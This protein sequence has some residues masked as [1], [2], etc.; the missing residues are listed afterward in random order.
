MT[1][2]HTQEGATQWLQ[3]LG[4]LG[5][6]IG[7]FVS[8]GFWFVDLRYQQAVDIVGR[9]IVNEEKMAPFAVSW[10]H[11]KNART[12]VLFT[13]STI[14][15]G[16]D[17]H[18]F[19]SSMF[20]QLPPNHDEVP[21]KNLC[22]K[23]D[24]SPF[25]QEVRASWETSRRELR[26]GTWW[27]V[28]LAWLKAGMLILVNK[29]RRTDKK[30]KPIECAR[31]FLRRKVSQDLRLRP[32][33]SP[34]DLNRHLLYPEFQ[35]ECKRRD[36]ERGGET[37]DPILEY[38]VRMPGL[39]SPWDVSVD[40]H[41]L[42]GYENSWKQHLQRIWISDGKPCIE[43]SRTELAALA[44]IMGIRI[45]L[46][47]KDSD[48]P[49]A[50]RKDPKSDVL[51]RPEVESPGGDGKLDSQSQLFGQGYPRS[52]G[53]DGI[54]G[55]GLYGKPLYGDS[56][57]LRLVVGR[58]EHT[59]DGPSRGSGYSTLFAKCMACGCV[60]FETTDRWNRVI[61][62]TK[63]TLKAIKAGMNIRDGFY[64]EGKDKDESARPQKYLNRLPS[65]RRISYY[66]LPG[67]LNEGKIP[68]VC[69]VDGAPIL[70]WPRVVAGI[71]FG[72]LVPMATLNLVRAIR[73]TAE[74][75]NN[76]VEIA[77]EQL[78]NIMID[79]QHLAQFHQLFGQDIEDAAKAK[80][81][82]EMEKMGNPTDASMARAASA[83]SH[84]STILEYAIA[85][86]AEPDAI[87]NGGINVAPPVAH[88]TA[89]QRRH[90]ARAD[91]FQACCKELSDSFLIARR[92]EEPAN[93]HLHRKDET[94]TATV[95]KPISTHKARFDVVTCGRIAR[96][97][98]LVWSYYVTIVVWNDEENVEALK[99]V[100]NNKDR[101]YHPVDLNELPRSC[102]LS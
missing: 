94:H 85:R 50:A 70:A 52:L 37:Q 74:G 76:T 66:G 93:H 51:D 49:S 53:G 8:F 90:R 15:K 2:A 30:W 12:P 42:L 81:G 38:A 67:A 63:G 16:G 77:L 23:L 86:C 28:G 68:H 65:A 56:W 39:K 47:Y 22:H 72:G 14:I 17:E 32:M 83:I 4:A 6:F 31:R 57:A 69:T 11:G 102:F 5:T 101:V 43:V 64:E 59:S 35:R 27:A 78:W 97:I 82:E 29:L 1:L 60:P 99:F 95:E 80:E 46:N 25:W 88:E 75:E 48:S 45:H 13:I 84:L 58:V 36:I 54:F 98:I 92:S 21:G 24:E 20:D 7:V 96:Y 26:I 40:V 18:V 19:T 33:Q 73:F 10:I 87:L 79:I 91:V 71:A 3:A 55:R 34:K 62:I 100:G 44:L 41:P 61:F 9:T 89:Q